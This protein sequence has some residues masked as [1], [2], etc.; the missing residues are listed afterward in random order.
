MGFS[1][2]Y[3]RSLT[4]SRADAKNLFERKFPEDVEM[5]TRMV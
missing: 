1:V 5:L 3:R 2:L 4:L